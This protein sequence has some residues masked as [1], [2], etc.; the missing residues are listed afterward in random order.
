MS[1]AVRSVLGIQG[2]AGRVRSTRYFRSVFGAE[3][4]GQVLSV[5]TSSRAM[6]NLPGRGAPPVT[7]TLAVTTTPAAR[8]APPRDAPPPPPLPD[9][10]REREGEREGM[11][12]TTPMVVG[13]ILLLVVVAYFLAK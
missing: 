4:A 7:D 2:E 9:T 13:G 8:Q 5:A 12:I 11:K 1:A 3:G 6:A 10:V